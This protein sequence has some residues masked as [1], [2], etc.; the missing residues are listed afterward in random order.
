M[1]TLIIIALIFL[2]LLYLVFPLLAFLAT[3]IL[4][5]LVSGAVFEYAIELLG[6]IPNPVY[7]LLASVMILLWR[8]QLKLEQQLRDD[9][10]S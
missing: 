9:H 5:I 3:A 7:W 8:D 2:G 4:Y 1:T 6:M 10:H